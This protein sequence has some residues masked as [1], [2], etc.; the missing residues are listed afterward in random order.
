MLQLNPITLTPIYRTLLEN[1]GFAQILIAGSNPAAYFAYKFGVLYKGLVFL[2]ITYLIAKIVQITKVFV[3][4]GVRHTC[5][6]HCIYLRKK[7]CELILYSLGLWIIANISTIKS[8]TAEIY[9]IF[10][11]IIQP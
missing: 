3:V 5:F 4:A 11:G 9:S 6:C 1:Y 7:S 2:W 8:T 10:R